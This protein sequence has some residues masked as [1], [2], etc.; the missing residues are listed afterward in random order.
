M[1]T[2]VNY[3]H[4]SKSTAALQAMRR[5][6][7]ETYEAKAVKTYN[8]RTESVSTLV[9]NIGSTIHNSNI[10]LLDSSG[11]AVA[12]YLNYRFRSYLTKEA[13]TIIRS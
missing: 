9:C 7:S 5:A 11:Y 4:E 1:K 6:I 3:T 10:T 13:V 8:G 2:V 12:F